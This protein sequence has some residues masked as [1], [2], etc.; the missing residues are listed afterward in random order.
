MMAST[1]TNGVVAIVAMVVLLSGGGDRDVDCHGNLE[2]WGGAPVGAALALGPGDGQVGGVL[3]EGGQ[4]VLDERLELGVGPFHRGGGSAQPQGE[5]VGAPPG[6]RAGG[7]TVQ[8][9][10]H[11]GRGGRVNLGGV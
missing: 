4:H 8:A 3:V 11:G 1:S 5:P 10:N 6:G 7:D 9:Q 2:R